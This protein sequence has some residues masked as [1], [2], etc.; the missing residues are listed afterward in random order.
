[1]NINKSNGIDS[2]LTHAELIDE[3]AVLR[4]KLEFAVKTHETEKNQLKIIS[5]DLNLGFWE[6]D[7]IENRAIYYSEEYATIFGIGREELEQQYQTLYDFSKK[8]HPD[9]LENYNQN[10]TLSNYTSLK[11]SQGFSHEFRIIRPDGQVRHV[12][13]TEHLILNSDEEIISSYGVLQDI[14]ELKLTV[15][16]LEQSEESYSS[17]FFNLPIGVQEEITL[18]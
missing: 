7:E 12:K 13:E 6:W 10:L 15:R 2:A 5:K 11:T 16:A 3:V 14:T 1:M 17:L 18:Q 9:D 8:V 4:E